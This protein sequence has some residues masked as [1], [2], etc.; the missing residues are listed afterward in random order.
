M[1][2]GIKGQAI[3]FAATGNWKVTADRAQAFIWMNKLLL[4]VR[5]TLE[6][7]RSKFFMLFF[8]SFFFLQLQFN[9]KQ[10]FYIKY[11]CLQCFYKNTKVL[12][13]M[14]NNYISF[15]IA[16]Q[17]MMMHVLAKYNYV[18][19]HHPYSYICFLFP[20]NL[21]TLTA[22]TV[23]NTGDHQPGDLSHAHLDLSAGKKKIY[24]YIAFYCLWLQDY[25]ST[26]EVQSS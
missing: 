3:T 10:W 5:H 19:K 8:S 13:I 17:E 20:Q 24:I 9:Y 22:M 11:Y 14:E 2:Q 15:F 4:E 16:R 26:Q 12:V 21:L 25:F 6:F 18:Y 1:S 23:L 7:P